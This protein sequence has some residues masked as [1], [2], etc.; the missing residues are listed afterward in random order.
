MELTDWR[1]ILSAYIATTT[2]A[3]KRASSTHTH[4]VTHKSEGFPLVVCTLARECNVQEESPTAVLR[5]FQKQA[6]DFRI[7]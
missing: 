2:P 5:D 3:Q 7:Y 6:I 4:S 1:S